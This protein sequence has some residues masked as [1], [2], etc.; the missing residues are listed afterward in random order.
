[1]PSTEG[2][3][4]SPRVEII[5]R[6]KALRYKGGVV[7]EHGRRYSGPDLHLPSFLGDGGKPDPRETRLATSVAPGVKMIARD[8]DVEANDLRVDGVLEQPLRVV[9]FLS[10]PIPEPKRGHQSDAP[11]KQPQTMILYRLKLPDRA[12]RIVPCISQFFRS[13]VSLILQT[14]TEQFNLFRCC[15]GRV[16]L[17]QFC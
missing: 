7:A 15:H 17:A 9:L 13:S 11:F 10:R 5:K 8:Y 16:L 1:M 4:D 3:E 14:R 2:Y 6:R 12:T